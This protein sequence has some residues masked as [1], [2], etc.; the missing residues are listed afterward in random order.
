MKRYQCDVLVAGGG[1]AGLMAA[2]GAALNNASVMVAIKGRAQRSGATVMAPG[3]ISAVDDRWK[4]E[5]DSR[6]LHFEDTM[7]GGRFVNDRDMV[8]VLCERS[9]EL[10]LELERMGALFQREDDGASYSLR[11]DG[12]HSFPRCPFLEDRTGKEMLKAMAGA[13]RKLHVPLCEEVMVTRILKRGGRVTGAVGVSAVTGEAVIFDCSTV[14][15]AA[16]GAGMIYEN[17]DNPTDLTGDSYGLALGAGAPLRDMEFVQFYP[18][19]FLQ[20]PSMKGIFAGLLYYSRL[21]NAAGERFME[22][23]DPE[24]LELSTRDRVS[25]A[26]AEEVRQGRGT[27]GG[28]VYMDMT[29]QEPGFI[30]K[31][32]PALHS[33]Y[34]NMGLD[35]EKDRIEVAP[36]VHHFMGGMVV[37][38]SW[39]SN[40]PGLFGAG[41]ACGGMHGA[42]RLSQNALAEIIVSGMTAGESA[43]RYSANLPPSFAD[44]AEAESEE[45][46][47]RALLSSEAGE[48][49]GEVREKL[50]KTMGENGGV[51]RSKESLEKALAHI[52]ELKATPLRIRQKDTAM[53]RELIEAL[54]TE[55]MLKTAEAVARSA[56]AR[57][58]SRGA[59]FR[60]DFPEADDGRFMKNFYVAEGKDGLEVYSK[61]AGMKGASA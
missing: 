23:Y 12:G 6:E 47:V 10:V 36:T 8:K 39:S 49:P 28:G 26:I 4:K 21:Y 30:A 11:I 3:A 29:Y 24:R 53:N 41:E 37:D 32:T 16:G 35:P 33:T 58:E 61:S 40:V 7:E 51:F 17:S 31:M 25:M 38:A 56:L 52:A 5:G 42:N 48:T 44:P 43:A 46:K 22:R 50:R 54:E 14:I 45:H 57:E 2:Y 60:E 9:P 15:I 27:P 59:H 55:N 18:V 19:G 13:L 20:P 34:M 1:G